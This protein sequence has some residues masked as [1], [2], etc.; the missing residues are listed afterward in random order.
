VVAL[1]PA[2]YI[3]SIIDTEPLIARGPTAQISAAGPEADRRLA[4]T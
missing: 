2:S 1:Q 3:P 4:D